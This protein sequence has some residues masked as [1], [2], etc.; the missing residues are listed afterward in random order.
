MGDH[1][2][3]TPVRC[4]QP[5]ELQGDMARLYDAVA[6][7]FIASVSP[8]ARY[9]STQVQFSCGGE[10]F[11]AAG[12]RY[13]ELGF[14]R[15]CPHLSAEDVPLPALRKGELLPLAACGV[16]EG[17]TA[18][19]GYLTEAELIGLME[20]HGIG[21]DASIATHINNIATRNYVHVAGGRTLV[22]NP[23]GIVLVHGYHKVRCCRLPH[24]ERQRWRPY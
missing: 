3:I 19:P 22:P 15:I 14:L 12:K 10:G 23:L 20:K 2:P 7:H 6:R 5:G 13:T 1:P 18:A 8:D 4:A 17:R 24:G 21:T 11:S 16:K 9:T